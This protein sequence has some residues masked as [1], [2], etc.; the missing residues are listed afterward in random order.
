MTPL[1]HK[2]SKTMAK[3]EIA[4]IWLSAIILALPNGI[5]HNFDYVYDD[6]GDGNLKPFC[7][8]E[9]ISHTVEH[10]NPDLSKYNE[11]I[12]GK[13]HSSN[14]STEGDIMEKCLI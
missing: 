14:Y 4:I 3:L 10:Y 13:N 2:T 6:Y 7:T 1:A 5:F 9:E 8:P 11:T 12:Y